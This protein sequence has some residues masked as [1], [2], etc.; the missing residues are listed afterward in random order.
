[1]GKRQAFVCVRVC[2]RESVRVI[3]IEKEFYRM[4][5]IFYYTAYIL[6]CFTLGRLGRRVCFVC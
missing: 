2:V 1:M 6:K 5:V 3:V 4:I